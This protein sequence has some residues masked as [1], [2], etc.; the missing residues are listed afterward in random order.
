MKKKFL[1]LLQIL[2]ILNTSITYMKQENKNCINE[3]TLLDINT[4]NIFVAKNAKKR[5]FI[6]QFNY[7]SVSF[8]QKDLGSILGFFIVRDNTETSENIVNF[9]AS[10]IKKKYFSPIKKNAEEKFE[11]TLHHINRALEEIANIGN[12]EWLGKIDGAVCVIDATTI[13]FS[14]T[15]NAHILLLRDNSLMD[16]SKGLAHEEAAEQPLKTFVDISSGELC[17]NDKIIITSQE[18]LDLISLDELQKNAITFGQENFIQF[19]ETV[20]TNECSL[21]TATVIDV[22]EKEKPRLQPKSLQTKEIPSN[23][24]SADAFEEQ[25]EQISETI[26]NTELEKAKEKPSE[27]TDPRT[28]HI[29]IQGNNEPLPEQTII[30]SAQEKILESF[31]DIKE[32]I[33]I[34]W[35]TLSKK[36]FSLRNKENSTSTET[37]DTFDDIEEFDDIPDTILSDDDTFETPQTKEKLLNFFQIILEKTKQLGQI[38]HSTANNFIKKISFYYTKI[39][40]YFKNTQTKQSGVIENQ[41]ISQKQKNSFLPSMHHIVELWYKMNTHTKL[42]T[43]GILIFIIIVPLIFAKISQN[44]QKNTQKNINDTQQQIEN[45]TVEEPVVSQNP[46]RSNIDNPTSLLTDSSPI[47]TILVNDKLIGI[48]K[49][50]IVLLANGENKNFSLPADSGEIVIGTPMND[51]DLV[52]IL[53][54]KNKLYSFSPTTKKFKEQKNIPSF[55]YSKI[56]GLNTYMTY[57]YTL[58]EETITRYARIENGFDAGKNWLKENITISKD[59]TMAIDD[60]I[61]ITQD[62]K[63]IKLHQGKKMSFSQDASIQ[64][65]SNIYTTEDTD[66]MWILDTEND[67]LFKTKK[68]TGQKITE[69]T[70]PDFHDATSIVVSEQNNVAT[71]STPKNILSFKLETK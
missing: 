13:H 18:L 27:Y 34:K 17:P 9:L 10:E 36:F 8:T 6:E 37:V 50:N 58:N 70:H 48:T 65:V 53:T 47:S 19:I 44:N 52:F 11:S 23:A 33:A 54:T 26:D 61:Y 39:A 41:T 42:T 3:N 35:H 67:T 24:F 12:I 64:K 16:I 66:F 25:L 62:N 29:H 15:G 7:S 4:S 68:S 59:S 45:E 60:D 63:I 32:S 38:L 14:V 49:N 43:I 51:L 5:A 30:K 46:A 40:I 28:G 21:A 57:L 71:I 20:L 56:I 31:G 2:C 55:D 1:H 69:Y 22:Y